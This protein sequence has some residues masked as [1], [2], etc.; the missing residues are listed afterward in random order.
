MGE[1]K[2]PLLDRNLSEKF[3]VGIKDGLYI[4]ISFVPSTAKG[5]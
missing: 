1:A 3:I 4:E 2:I 5:V